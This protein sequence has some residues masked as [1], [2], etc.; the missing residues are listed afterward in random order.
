MLIVNEKYNTLCHIFES[1]KTNESTLSAKDYSKHN[2]AYALTIIDK[3]LN[4]EDVQTGKTGDGDIITKRAVKKSIKQKL[5]A[6]KDNIENTSVSDFNDAVKELGIRWT[7]LFKGALTGYTKGLATKNKGNA[8]EAWFIDNYDNPEYEI[9]SNVKAIAKYKKR[10]GKPRADGS[11]NKKRPLT[12]SGDKITCGQPGNYNIGS[13]VTDVTI[14]VDTCVT[15][16]KEVYLS[17]KYGNTVT[18]VNA[19]VK[20]LFNEDFFDGGELTGNGKALLNMLCINEDKF[21][22]VFTSYSGSGKRKADYSKD[23]ITDKLK[24]NKSFKEFMQSVMGYGYILVHQTSKRDIEYIDL[25]TEQAMQNFV[26]DI[27][28]A[29]VEYPI[30]G[31]AKRVNVVVKYPQIEF[32]INI[33]SKDGGTYP[34]HIMADYKF[35]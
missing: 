1:D 20:K 7:S 34:T 2:F 15:G 17:L 12:F 6:L 30:G 28:S 4:G 18:F 27:E 25:M 21:R 33:R 11:L 32:S 26:S 23:N 9:E 14:P 31:S 3:L 10:T 8:F 29:V 16:S 5:Q 35:V 24:S 19:G 13:T 22:D